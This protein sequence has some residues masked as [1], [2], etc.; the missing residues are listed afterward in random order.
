MPAH[1]REYRVRTFYPANAQHPHYDSTVFAYSQPSALEH[2]LKKIFSFD[3]VTGQI[4]APLRAELVPE[5]DQ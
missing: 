2:A 5:N 4:V 3:K 1:K